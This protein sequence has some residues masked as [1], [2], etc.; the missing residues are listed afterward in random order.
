QAQACEVSRSYRG[1]R[2][3][4][5]EK[6]TARRI[7]RHRAAAKPPDLILADQAAVRHREVAMKRHDVALV[8]KLRE[9]NAGGK[10]WVA[11]QHADAHCLEPS[12]HARADHPDADDADG[13]EER[14]AVVREVLPLPPPVE[15]CLLKTAKAACQ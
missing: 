3:F 7:Q 4:D 10:L 13:A 6:S 15:R 14:G 8:E 9:G 2:R 1:D 12:R 5:V 11:A